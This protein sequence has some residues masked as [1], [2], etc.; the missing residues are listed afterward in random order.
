MSTVS[1]SSCGKQYPYSADIAGR[2][3]RCRACGNVFAVPAETPEGLDVVDAYPVAGGFGGA[4]GP[5]VN[6]GGRKADEIEYEIYGSEM[7]F[8]EITL[9]PNEMV[10]AEAGGMMYMSN[11]IKM[12]TVFGDPQPVESRLLGQNDVGRQTPDDRRVAVHDYVYGCVE[13]P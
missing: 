6:R 8:C 4:A 13:S 5:N 10:I 9:D 2:Q 11:G 1:C 12:E 3:V 7:Q